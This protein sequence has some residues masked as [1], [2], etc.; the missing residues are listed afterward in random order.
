M[1]ME[2]PLEIIEFN[3]ATATLTKLASLSEAVV[4]ITLTPYIPMN[5]TTIH[6]R[7][8]SLSSDHDG[9]RT[10]QQIL[11]RT[12]PGAVTLLIAPWIAYFVSVTSPR[13]ADHVPREISADIHTDPTL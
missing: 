1:W 3:H 9:H 10:T 6:E 7:A 5:N 2:A 4:N 11:V 13:F 12:I 8:K